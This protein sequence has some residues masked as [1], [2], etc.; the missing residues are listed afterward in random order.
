M[1]NNL[2]IGQRLIVLIA[3]Q[4]FILLFVG[5]ISVY[6]LRSGTTATVLLNDTVATSVGFNNVIEPL[7][8]KLNE[9]MNNYEVGQIN[10]NEAQ[11]RVNKIESEFNS[12]WQVLNSSVVGSE[13][14]FIAAVIKPHLADVNAGFKRL[15]D[16]FIAGDSQE[17]LYFAKEKLPFLIA[18]F[19][20]TVQASIAEQNQVSKN[21]LYDSQIRENSILVI[22]VVSFIAGILV[23]IV[24]SII[25]YQSIANPISAISS[26]VNQV[27]EGNLSVRTNLDGGDELSILGKTLDSL[28]QDKMSLLALSEKENKL[29]NDS[30]INLLKAVSRLSQRDLTINVPVTEDVTGPLAD[31][32]NKLTK[33]TSDVLSKV[34]I[35]AEQVGEASVNVDSKANIVKSVALTQQQDLESTADELSKAS[36]QL[37]HI[38]GEANQCNQIAV[39]A[40]K[41]TE[42][43]SKT[44]MNTLDGMNN[45]RE[46]IN[47]AGKRIKRLGERSQEIGTV[48]DLIKDVAE[49]THVLALNSSVQA[50][51]AGEA[52]RGFAIIAEEVRR[53]AENAKQATADISSLVKN[54]Q[55]ETN[56]TMITMEKTIG[57]VVDGSKLAESAGSQMSET[58]DITDELVKSVQEIAINTKQQA[59]ISNQLR[60]RAEAL[61]QSTKNTN[62]ELDEQ[63]SQTRSLTDFCQQLISSVKIFK[64][65][66][67]AV[68]A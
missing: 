31:A 13:Q 23:S 57:Y 39:K 27:A 40:G 68:Q 63:L 1:F 61:N 33:D 24:L 11:N 35:V 7:R 6:G 55:I 60:D 15:N 48:V 42:V 41:A 65:P 45:I 17:L 14:E 9:T 51:A 50:A 30:I 19:V 26:T 34:T 44:V 43:A 67:K 29:L 8:G 16:I 52:G 2:K 53:L 28:L 54:I 49:R 37:N 38:V 66:G 22:T 3:L 4:A 21:V 20:S 62:R 47:E 10:W 64:L 32:I 59:N 12:S 46:T 56:D 25:I 18:P 58:R 5:I 36:E